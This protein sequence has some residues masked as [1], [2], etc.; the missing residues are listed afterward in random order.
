MRMSYDKVTVWLRKVRTASG[1]DRVD[2]HLNRSSSLISLEFVMT[3][4][5]LGNDPVA[6][7]R[8]SDFV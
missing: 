8:G 3:V 1:S 7:A 6:T 2:T 5:S 4:E